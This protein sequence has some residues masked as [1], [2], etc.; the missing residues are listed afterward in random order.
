[1]DDVPGYRD[2]FDDAPCGYLVLDGRGRITITNRTLRS[3]LD[4]E[5]GDLVG[6]RLIDLLPVAGRMFYETHFAPLLRM[7]GHFHEVALDFVRRD[8]T[9]LPVL[10]NANQKI[11]D[12][13]EVVETRIAVFQA[14]SR[15]KYERELFD[16]HQTAKAARK[17]VEQLNLA[18]TKTGLL[19]D[20]FI[21]V[22]GHDLRNPLAS[23]KS[24]LRMLSQESLSERGVEIVR[25]IEGSADRMNGLIGDVLDLARGRLGGGL[26]LARKEELEL[27]PVLEQVVAELESARG[28]KIDV[29]IDLP[30]PAMVDS[31][32]IAQLVSNLLGNALTHG[33][34]DVP[35]GLT[36]GIEQGFL[37]IAVSNGGEAI[38][39]ETME[40]LF[41]PFFRGGEP[42]GRQDGLGLGLHIASEIAKAHGGTLTVTSSPHLTTFE[43]RMPNLLPNS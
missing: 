16:A 20:E 29:L 4:L 13:N 22:M 42:G 43:F 28:R 9:R 21:A 23:V 33:S 11:G 10:A 26:A 12:N 17:E 5:G 24:G 27:Q 38:P 8:G 7:Q 35:I 19:R 34:P 31:A 14:T 6:K 30:E 39:P 15:R 1:M 2:L 18:L 41:Q 37:T 40:R 36:V 3:W 25:L 32:R